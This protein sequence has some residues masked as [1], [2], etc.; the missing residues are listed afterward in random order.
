MLLT[1][2]TLPFPLSFTLK[3]NDSSTPVVGSVRVRKAWCG[4]VAFLPSTVVSWSFS[5]SVAPSETDFDSG[6]VGLSLSCS[7][8]YV[9]NSA[10]ART[11]LSFAPAP[12]PAPLLETVTVASSKLQEEA[13]DTIAAELT[14][15]EGTSDRRNLILAVVVLMWSCL[16]LH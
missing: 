16:K 3:R 7:S 6:D 8:V 11:H 13:A 2:F 14:S 1:R 9:I 12:T 4:L 15:R 5:V 10:S